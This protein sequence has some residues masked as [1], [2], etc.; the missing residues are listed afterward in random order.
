MD[1]A[2]DSV[3]ITGQETDNVAP[4]CSGAYLSSDTLWPPEHKYVTVDISGVS[5][6]DGD[7]VILSIT[8][9]TQDEPTNGLGDGDVS[10]DAVITDGG[11][12]LRRERSGTGNGRVYQIHVSGTDPQGLSCNATLTVGVPHQKKSTPVDDGQNYDA[13]LP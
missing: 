9:V 8:G 11:V 13:T 7:P 12:K 4:D 5:D 6:P 1:S 10:P 3:I 2:P